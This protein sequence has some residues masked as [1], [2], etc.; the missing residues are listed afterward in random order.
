MLWPASESWPTCENPWFYWDLDDSAAQPD[1]A[2]PHTHPNPLVPVLQLFARD[3]PNLTYPPRADLLQV[4]WC[5]VTHAQLPGEED[6]YS[7]AVLVKWRDSTTLLGA[8]TDHPLPFDAEDELVAAP[9]ALHPEQV[10]EYPIDLPQ[11]LWN[12]ID[13][14]EDQGW[15]CGDDG[16]A[17]LSDLSVA[18]GTK[19]GGWP[20]WH[21]FDPYPMPCVACGRQLDLLIAFGTYERD[22]GVGHWDPPDISDLG[23]D[24]TTGLSLGRGGDLQ[25][26]YCTTNPLHP[27]HSHVQG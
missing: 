5:P 14:A 24:D 9:C 17:Y 6:A 7:P 1:E 8:A 19:A 21:S 23:L 10:D 18:P 4:L 26:F 20:R 3:A 2:R 15:N 16:V 12:R 13:V 11:E 27:V 25:I 22:D